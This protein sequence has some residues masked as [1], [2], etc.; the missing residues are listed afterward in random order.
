MA[1]QPLPS[2][3]S[4]N[5]TMPTINTL[6]TYANNDIQAHLSRFL[7]ASDMGAVNLNTLS[8]VYNRSFKY[9]NETLSR[10][11]EQVRC[12][13]LLDKES[14]DVIF[15]Y[16]PGF[17]LKDKRWV[18]NFLTGMYADKYADL[19]K[20]YPS[21]FTWLCFNILT[22][23][24]N[25]I[26]TLEGIKAGAYTGIPINNM[27]IQKRKRL[28]VGTTV[29]NN[30]TANSSNVSDHPLL[31]S[32]IFNTYAAI[33]RISDLLKYAIPSD[34][35]ALHAIH[36]FSKKTIHSSGSNSVIRP[37]INVEINPPMVVDFITRKVKDFKFNNM[38]NHEMVE[39]IESLFTDNLKLTHG[40]KIGNNKSEKEKGLE[41]AAISDSQ[42]SSQLRYAIIKSIVC[43][44]DSSKL[45]E[46]F[47]ASRCYSDSEF[48]ISGKVVMTKDEM[49]TLEASFS[50]EQC[51]KYSRQ[52]D[53][54]NE[55]R[56]NSNNDVAENP[57]INGNDNDNVN[58][59][60]NARS[61]NST[62]DAVAK[63]PIINGNE[64]DNVDDNNNN[65]RSSNATT[66]TTI[67][68]TTTT[69]EEPNAKIPKME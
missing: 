59:N 39:Y 45:D 25:K 9:E 27:N 22:L 37:C 29:N 57:I 32:S 41:L 50:S 21:L 20:K 30:P 66:S 18:F 53:N 58:C 6:Q 13:N 34:F 68:T 65:A 7:Q 1:Q 46:Q 49:D 31:Q 48:Y 56:E 10:D 2:G 33:F 4:A 60:N 8:N 35:G 16:G 12:M 17:D 11:F 43:F 64:D 61:D 63:N 19:M 55:T 38:T 54:Y 40:L 51:D 5:Q 62:T 42:E 36:T 47:I 24:F 14:M 23:V 67:N 15:S 3:S 44:I 52:L 26:A 69:N 28:R